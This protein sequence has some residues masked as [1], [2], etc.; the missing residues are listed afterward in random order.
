LGLQELIP[1]SL[2]RVFL[3]KLALAAAAASLWLEH[4]L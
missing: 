2:G 3:F 1:S 4:P